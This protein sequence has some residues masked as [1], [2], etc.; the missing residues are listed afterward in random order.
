M[1]RNIRLFPSACPLNASQLG[2]Y[3]ECVA[4]AESINIRRR[5][6]G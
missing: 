5:G 3:M 2:V 6:F 4:D 1:S